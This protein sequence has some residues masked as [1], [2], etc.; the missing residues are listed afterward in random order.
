M[1]RRRRRRRR[2]RTEDEE[3]DEE[4]Q[5]NEDE[6]DDEQQHFRFRT[7]FGLSQCSQSASVQLQCAM[8]DRASSAPAGVVA[9]RRLRGKTSAGSS[10]AYHAAAGSSGASQPVAAGGAGAL[11]N[12]TAQQQTDPKQRQRIEELMQEVRDFGRWPKETAKC[13]PAERQLAN[14]VRR[15][16]KANQFSPEE[17]VELQALQQADTKTDD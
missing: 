17:E 6:H 7:R 3:E 9:A 16:R 4:L 2:R 15:A 5:Q 8:S 14:K 10:G 13:S 12:Q 1:R 11:A